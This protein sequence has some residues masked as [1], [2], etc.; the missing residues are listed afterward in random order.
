MDNGNFR[1][2]NCSS[3]DPRRD[4]VRKCLHGHAF[5]VLTLVILLFIPSFSGIEGDPSNIF[6]DSYDQINIKDDDE[7]ASETSRG[8]GT[9]PEVIDESDSEARTGE[10]FTLS[11]TVKDNIEVNDASASF[12]VHGQWIDVDLIKISNNTWIGEF[13]IPH[14]GKILSY[15]IYVNNNNKDND[16][17]S[18]GGIPPPEPQVSREIPIQDTIKPTIETIHCDEPR[19][20][21]SMLIKFLTRDNIEVKRGFFKYWFDENPPYNISGIP[22]SFTI[23]VQENAS[24]MHYIVGASD[25][26][27]NWRVNQTS[28][29]V[30]D[31]GLPLIELKVESEPLTSHHLSLRPLLYDLVSIKECGIIYG[32]DNEYNSYSLYAENGTFKIWIPPES[33]VI[34]ITGWVR[35]YGLNEGCCT[36][37][38][39]IFDGTAPYIEHAQVMKCGKDRISFMVEASD[40]RGV[41]RTWVVVEDGDITVDVN[42]TPGVVVGSYYGDLW[43]KGMKDGLSCT[44]FASDDSGNVQVSPPVYYEIRKTSMNNLLL[45]FILLLFLGALA[46][47][48]VIIYRGRKRMKDRFVIIPNHEGHLEEDPYWVL[49]LSSR[50]SIEN[51][52]K[53]YRILAKKY[54][55]DSCTMLDEGK[56]KRINRAK[57]ILIDSAKKADLDG[58]KEKNT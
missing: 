45:L 7:P 31:I 23:Y 53:R 35:D 32:F 6:P 34:H 36:M 15:H 38:I 14:D 48:G 11:F 25:N 19:T 12:S 46:V 56:M 54:H 47:A 28:L 1:G 33:H 57:E 26:E 51:I 50:A 22:E 44:F 2:N 42:L 40:N 18:G 20:G 58:K 39:E 37:D 55:P 16:L 49:G 52:K 21:R 41:K 9:D 29:D 13:I 10:I 27:G 17:N 24:K 4:S 43:T 30:K 5:I 8:S 3:L